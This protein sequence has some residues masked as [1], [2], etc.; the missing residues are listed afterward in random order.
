[1]IAAGESELSTLRERLRL[2][3]GNDWEKLSE[4]ARQEQALARK[5]EAMMT[6]WSELGESLA[7]DQAT[8]AGEQR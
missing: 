8:L 2:A 1:M 7:N 5:V 6:E 3:P 4:W